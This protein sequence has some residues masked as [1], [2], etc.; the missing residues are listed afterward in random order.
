MKKQ[1]NRAIMAAML[2]L[3]LVLCLYTLP[4]KTMAATSGKLTYTVSD[5]KATITS[6]DPSVSGKFTI[7]SEL[8]GYPVTAI[9]TWAFDECMDLTSLVIPEGVTRIGDHAFYSTNISSITIP[10]TLKEV[11]QMLFTKSGQLTELRIA[12]LTSF[13]NIEFRSGSNE[14]AGYNYTLY[15]NN[16]LAKELIIPEGITEIPNGA[17]NSCSGIQQVI[18]PEGL[19]SIGY[20]AFWGCSALS[21]V[22]LPDSLTYVGQ[23]AFGNNNALKYT[24]QDNIKYLGNTQ[25]PCL[26]LVKP[27]STDVT[28]LTLPAGT[29]VIVQPGFRDYSALERVNV[30]ESN[31]YFSNDEA[32]VLYNKDKTV[33][34]WAPRTLKGSYTV[35]STVKK[36]DD[37]AFYRCESLTEVVLPKKLTEIGKSAFWGC[38]KLQKMDLPNSL[39]YIGQDAFDGCHY[40][41]FA[42]SSWGGS[43]LGNEDNPHLLLTTASMHYSEPSFTVCNGTKIIGSNA[44]SS[45]LHVKNVNLGSSIVIIGNSAFCA[46]DDLKELILPSSLK[47]IENGAFYRCESLSNIYIPEGT[48]SIGDHAL[49]HCISLKNIQLPSTITQITYGMLS[50]CTSLTQVELPKNVQS[51][52][53][54]AFANCTAL[55]SI[56]IND[57]VKEIGKGAFENCPALKN[58]YFTGTQQQW[59]EIAVAGGN[60][61]LKNATVHYE[62]CILSQPEDTAV[63][64]GETAEL[65]IAAQGELLNY[66]WQYRTAADEQWINCTNEGSQTDC[67]RITADPMYNN[68]E[69]RCVITDGA[70]QMT[71]SRIVKLSVLQLQITTQPV[72]VSAI[73]GTQRGFNVEAVGEGLNYQWQSRSSSSSEWTDLLYREDPQLYVSADMSYNG[74]E[75]RCLIIDNYGNQ[76]YSEIATLQVAVLEF[77]QDAQDQHVLNGTTVEF[78]VKANGT[79]L[80]Y[81]WMYRPSALSPAEKISGEGS[82]T[83]T[84]RVTATSDKDYSYYYC[85]VTDQYGNQIQSHEATLYIVRI[86][87]AL[88]PKNCY[89]VIGSIAEFKAIARGGI[90]NYQWQYRTSAT[91]K[92]VKAQASGNQTGTL[93]VPVTV[94]RD[95]YQYRCKFTDEY[96]NVKYSKSATLKVNRIK[97]TSQPSNKFLPTGKTA[98]FTVKASGTGLQYQW[99][100]RTSSKGSWKNASATGNKTANLSVPATALRNGYQY[101]CK[102]TDKYDNV[103]YSY[104]VTLKIVTL[105]ITTQ[106]TSVTLAKGKTATFKVVAKGTDLT[107]QWQYRTSAKDSWK[108]TTATGNKTVTLKVPVTAFR[109]GYQYRCVITDKYGNVINSGAATL[110]VKN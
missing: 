40:K 64:A 78:S 36:I 53:Q 14:F 104:V 76:L 105:K 54:E 90:I 80:Q 32:G 44:F 15:I 93:K 67:L 49:S 89:K 50:S 30:N 27:T 109:N 98:K 24:V 70:Q 46:C 100:Y 63:L 97:I 58:V 77:T 29:K 88:Q 99:Q 84:L 86:N 45:S 96:G 21:T 103:L 57:Q 17:F 68:Y 13:L 48:Q 66:Q 81:Q 4:G 107:Y 52:D 91:G 101:R 75:Y 106:P 16:E 92:W 51:I 56:V 22:T 39:L 26:L 55:E 1:I 79:G 43:Y 72:N 108:K 38:K 5:G 2:A 3:L 7:P 83:D 41:L 42:S 47:I 37:W 31:P 33:L 74:Y 19:T 94:G 73:A 6:C 60:D 10:S 59:S 20:N 82:N 102:I 71:V 61:T 35:A 23:S 85:L 34:Y 110:K 28:E 25:N 95:G 87:I 9:D 8:G 65:K 62:Y 18:L 11:G 69:Y 12:D